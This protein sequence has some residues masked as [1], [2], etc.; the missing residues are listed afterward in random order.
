MH[1]FYMYTWAA[2]GMA[3]QYAGPRLTPGR[4][5]VDPWLTPG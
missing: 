2:H 1:G 4:P 3:V 5:Q